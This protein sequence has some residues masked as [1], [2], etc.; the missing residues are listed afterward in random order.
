MP[1][2]M[3][4]KKTVE[5]YDK[6]WSKTTTSASKIGN[7]PA[8][9]RHKSLL[10]HVRKIS[11]EYAP[12][13]ARTEFPSQMHLLFQNKARTTSFGYPQ[14]SPFLGWVPPFWGGSLNETENGSTYPRSPWNGQ[15]N[16]RRTLTGPEEDFVLEEWLC[17]LCIT[18]TL[19]SKFPQNKI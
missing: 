1:C 18:Q 10:P 7:T 9:F 19:L 12:F 4:P 6:F 13:R 16:S 2:R 14:I 15:N 8:K 5:P 11:N 3:V 17:V